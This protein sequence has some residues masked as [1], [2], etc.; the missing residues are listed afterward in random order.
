MQR[1]A[2]KKGN[3]ES[4][5]DIRHITIVGILCFLAFFIQMLGYLSV[6]ILAATGFMNGDT[7]IP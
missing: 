7:I 6:T 5:K 1:M 2:D 3:P 4:T